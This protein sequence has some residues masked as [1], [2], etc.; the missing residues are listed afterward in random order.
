[1]LSEYHKLNYHKVTIKAFNFLRVQSVDPLYR[2]RSALLGQ[3]GRCNL[4]TA[5][6]ILTRAPSVLRLTSHPLVRLAGRTSILSG[7]RTMTH[8]WQLAA[9]Y[10][11]SCWLPS[12]KLTTLCEDEEEVSRGRCSDFE[13]T[14]E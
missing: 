4:L 7:T 3:P 2:A 10:C 1:M 9:K 11:A 6:D 13:I 14:E 12:R 8:Q 5:M